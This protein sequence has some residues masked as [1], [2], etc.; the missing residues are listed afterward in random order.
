MDCGRT[1]IVC[2]NDTEATLPHISTQEYALKISTMLIIVVLVL[3]SNTAI[4]LVLWTG[5]YVASNVKYIMTFVCGTDIAVGAFL[6]VSIINALFD[7]WNF[8]RAICILMGTISQLLIGLTLWLYQLLLIDKYIAIEFPFKHHV[9]M[10][11]KRTLLAIGILMILLSIPT[12]GSEAFSTFSYDYYPNIYNCFPVFQSVNE[13]L[14]SNYV[15]FVCGFFP[16]IVTQV[17]LNARI[18]MIIRRHRHQTNPIPNSNVEISNK[19]RGLK[20]IIIASGTSYI[21]Y[22][23]LL[24]IIFS[25][26]WWGLDAPDIVLFYAIMMIYCSSCANWLIYSYSYQPFR[27]D[28]NRLITNIKCWYNNQ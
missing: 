28:Q 12:I 22:S 25:S 10:S 8:G 7:R 3:V 4:L 1:L 18:Y 14:K 2:N 13:S 19:I 26:G 5:V 20:T 27:K 24:M 21:T 6:V 11:T 16:T 9:L 23:P 15:S 17:V